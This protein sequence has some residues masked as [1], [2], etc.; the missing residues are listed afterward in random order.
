M[1]GERSPTLRS[2]LRGTHGSP[3]QWTSSWRRWR[4]PALGALLGR[5]A[6]E[7]VRRGYGHTLREIAQQPVTWIETASRMH[8][9]RSLARGERRLG[10]GGRVHGL[11][12]LPLRRGMRRSVPAARARRPGLRR[13]RRPD[14]HPSGE[15]PSPERR[16]SSSCRSPV[17]ATAPRAGRWST[18]C[19]RSGRRRATSSSPA[20]ATGP[21]PRRYRDRA[22]VRTIVLDEQTNDRSLVMT[23][24]FTN[25][26]LAGRA[27]AGR[28]RGLRAASRRARAGGGR[29]AARADL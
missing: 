25:M 1:S 26:V 12:Q 11:G 13:A 5:P 9:V 20:T 7:Q 18:S 17:R 8:A 29:P 15:L 19:S 10:L 22:E 16:R 3:R 24:S 28:P 6:E 23:S 14:P 4:R 27:L 2:A 21:W